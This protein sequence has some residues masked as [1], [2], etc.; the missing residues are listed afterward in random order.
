[1]PDEKAGWKK[2]AAEPDP[3]AAPQMTEDQFTRLLSA[4]QR[5]ASDGGITVTQ[6]AEVLESQRKAGIRENAQAPMQS[7]YSNPKGDRDDPKP[8]L[9]CAMYFCGFPLEI[10]CL[11][12]EEVA[13]LNKVKPG[14]Y[15]VTKPDGTKM[16]FDVLPREDD[17]GKLE[18]LDLNMPCKTLDQRTG[19]GSFR[20]MLREITTGIPEHVSIAD[21]I[22]ENRAL[23]QQHVTADALG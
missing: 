12:P 22:A 9:Q 14:R 21:L 16:K 7:V 2:A 10:D 3:V 11:D 13:L 19:L 6:F 15:F 5:P 23:R 4:I 18:R 17:L 20:S 1:M 8:K